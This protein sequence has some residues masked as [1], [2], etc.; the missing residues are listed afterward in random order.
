M[1]MEQMTAV[2]EDRR[3]A[4][5]VMESLRSGIPTRLSTRLLPDLRKNITDQIHADLDQFGEET[6]Q[7]GRAHV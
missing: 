4:I 2:S 7:I 5:F 3:N 6:T 1:N